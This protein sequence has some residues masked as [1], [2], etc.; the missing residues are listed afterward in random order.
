[1]PFDKAL[2]SL[3]TVE[4]KFRKLFNLAGTI[5]ASFTPT[6][7][8]VVIVG[9]TRTA[10]YASF[11]GRKW[12]WIS[13]AGTGP[14]TSL[15][16]F[17]TPVDLLLTGVTC[18]LGGGAGCN[19]NA[20][21]FEPTR[22]LPAA[23]VGTLTRPCGTWIDQKATAD[24]APFLD[25][26]SWLATGIGANPETRRFAGWQADASSQTYTT[27]LTMHIP[28]NSAILFDATITAG[29]RVQ[30]GLAGEIF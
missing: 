19:V 23:M 17:T 14:I 3:A 27:A 18:M 1:M 10:G 8:P 7:T 20:Q 28:A 11:K 22:A 24:S 5:G 16:G 2:T 13:D 21:L 6:I 26:A 12:A 25:R 15:M 4:E 30:V 9:D 29:G